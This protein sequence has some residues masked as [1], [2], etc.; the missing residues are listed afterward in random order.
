VTEFLAGLERRLAASTPLEAAVARAAFRAILGG[1]PVT[2][3]DLETGMDVG[4]GDV[5]G[6]VARL[7]ERGTLVVGPDEEVL[8]VRGLS[9]RPT[10]HVLELPGRR[11]YALCAVDAIGIPVALG[12]DAAVRSR[13]HAC[14]QPLMLTVAGGRLQRVPPGT[15]IWAADHDDR[16]LHAHT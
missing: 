8:A 15:V 16:P 13:C 9:R 14:G 12:L 11:L 4:P 7:R 3:G 5:G 10:T 2:A 1:R 6:A